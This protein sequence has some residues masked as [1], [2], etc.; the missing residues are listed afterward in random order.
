MVATPPLKR[1][2]PLSHVAEAFGVHERTI[3]RAIAEGRI[4][5]VRVGRQIRISEDEIAK[6]A[7]PIRTVGGAA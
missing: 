2:H 3:R 1:Y 6:L 5:A 7:T 4:Q